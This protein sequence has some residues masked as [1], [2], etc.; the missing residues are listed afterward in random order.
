M[1]RRWAH[2][3]PAEQAAAIAYIASR[4]NPSC[5]RCNG[6]GIVQSGPQ[7]RK[8]PCSC[9]GEWEMRTIPTTPD[10]WVDVFTEII[11]PEIPT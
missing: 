6:S 11:P 3:D 8:R 9:Q 2:D 7:P 1:E 10:T 5:Q 4:V